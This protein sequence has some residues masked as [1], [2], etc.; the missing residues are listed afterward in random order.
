MQPPSREEKITIDDFRRCIDSLRR[1]NNDVND[2]FLVLNKM[3]WLNHPILK[4]T[5]TEINNANIEVYC[6]YPYCEIKL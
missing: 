2:I 6:F 5:E 4:W 3:E 1:Q